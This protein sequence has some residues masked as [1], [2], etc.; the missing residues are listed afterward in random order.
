MRASNLFLCSMEC[1]STLHFNLPVT[2][3]QSK[4]ED[5]LAWIDAVM[6]VL[7]SNVFDS[8]RS[9]HPRH[10]QKAPR[11]TQR[12]E[13]NNGRWT[14]R[15]R[16]E[17]IATREI[18]EVNKAEGDEENVWKMTCVN[19][20]TSSWSYGRAHH[21]KDNLSRVFRYYYHCRGW[22]EK[23][24]RWFG[25]QSK[26]CDRFL[27]QMLTFR[28]VRKKQLLDQKNWRAGH[29]LELHGATRSSAERG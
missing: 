17:W 13:R 4:T 7:R 20:F 5:R 24:R 18:V 6:S 3:T 9:D 11:E 16:D 23:L 26:L 8:T 19:V 14:D 29:L 27:I 10:T 12:N 25:M 21:P 15:G 28:Y 2:H 1:R 22:T